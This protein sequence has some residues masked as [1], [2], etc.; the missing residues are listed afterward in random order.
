[1][2]GPIVQVARRRGATAIVLGDA[3]AAHGVPIIVRAIVNIAGKTCAAA[4]V[5]PACR[6]F[7]APVSRFATA[8]GCAIPDTARC[9]A[10]LRAGG[11][12]QG[13]GT[14]PGYTRETI[15]ELIGK[16][17]G[18]SDWVLLDQARIDQFA[19]LTNDHQFIHVD[20]ERARRTPLGGTIAHGFLTLSMLGDLVRAADFAMAGATW[21]MN[22]GFDRIR[23]LTPVKSGSRIR[24]RFTLKA[25]DER[26][27]GQWMGRLEVV[28]EIEGESR[29]ALVAEWL[30]LTYVS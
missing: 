9:R 20:P 16:E 28:V 13:Q 29:P 30:T 25:M 4:P 23:F 8:S 10:Q 24:G 22:Y 27:P 18:L 1:V 26:S 19:A 5:W 3:D 21:G 11:H 14:M 15:G 12:P 17:V 7:P 2:L 6:D